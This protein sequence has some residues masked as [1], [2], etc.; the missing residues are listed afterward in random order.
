MRNLVAF[1]ILALAV[2]LQS[3]IVSRIT[4]LSGVADLCLVIVIA[5]ALQN[6]VTTGWH[7]AIVG[8]AFT[9]F[10]SGLPWTVP[11]FGFLAAVWFAGMFQRRIWQAPMLAMLAVTFLATLFY[12]LLSFV[13]L[14]FSGTSL[15][16]A[17]TFSLITLPSVLLNMF[18]SLPIYWWLRDLAGWVY[19]PEE[20]E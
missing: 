6:G 8:G 17:D 1:P 3:A 14:S 4:L 5:W 19:P 18:L 2:I 12:H 15:P 11:V 9:A 7:W 13:A 10:V 20:E 16:F